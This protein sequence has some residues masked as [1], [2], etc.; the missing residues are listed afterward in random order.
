MLQSSLHRIFEDTPHTLPL[1]NLTLV[2]PSLSASK[3][4]QSKRQSSLNDSFFS[5][6]SNSN[7]K[8]L[9]LSNQ[10][11]TNKNTHHSQSDTSTSEL[12]NKVHSSND[13]QNLLASHENKTK[14]SLAHRVLESKKSAHGTHTDAVVTP[15]QSQ[16]GRD[17]R[18]RKLSAVDV[19]FESPNIA[20]EDDVTSDSAHD[21]IHGL[22]LLSPKPKDRTINDLLKTAVQQ[23]LHNG[24]GNDTQKD[25]HSKEA[26]PNNFPDKYTKPP[27]ESDIFTSVSHTFSYKQEN[28]SKICS[29]SPKRKRKLNLQQ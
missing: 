28:S 26:S 12:E 16:F 21:Q 27:Y 13:T 23:T 11:S 18:K 6:Q 22:T 25:D 15:E 8:K 4:T 17:V 29:T 20:S 3:Q 1:N 2:S 24:S 5:I 7:T 10:T 9:T 19:S 14:S